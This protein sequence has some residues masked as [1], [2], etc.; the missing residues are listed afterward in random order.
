MNVLLALTLASL[1]WQTTAPA[2]TPARSEDFHKK[3]VRNG[4]VPDPEINF[5]PSM[6]PQQA[7]QQTSETKQLI[8]ATETNLKILQERG[9]GDER[10]DVIEEVKNYIS[11]ARSSLD[12]GDV[13]RAHK[14]A[15]KAGVLARDMLRH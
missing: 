12:S 13:E 1:L 3:I 15:I 14:L 5:E 8:D 6:T 11:L 2:A 9:P 7:A 10:Q 4:G